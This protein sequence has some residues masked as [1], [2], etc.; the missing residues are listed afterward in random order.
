MNFTFDV[1][2]EECRQAHA[3]FTHSGERLSS[4][5]SVRKLL[6]AVTDL[7]SFS[8]P[9]D[10]I[11]FI[12]IE[13]SSGTGKTQMAFTLEHLLHDDTGGFFYLLA[14]DLSDKSQPIYQYFRS[15]SASLPE[16]CVPDRLWDCQGRHHDVLFVWAFFNIKASNCN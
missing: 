15:V 2:T 3:T 8:K 4:N 9:N 11:P 16:A 12:F 7:R 5:T 14:S 6:G 1:K 13:G 10:D